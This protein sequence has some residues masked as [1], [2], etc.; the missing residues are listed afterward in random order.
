MD[1]QRQLLDVLDSIEDAFDTDDL[2]IEFSPNVEAPPTVVE[3][4]GALTSADETEVTEHD[5]VVALAPKRPIGEDFAIRR[6][7]HR[8]K[9]IVR[10]GAMP[11]RLTTS[12]YLEELYRTENL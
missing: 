9:P 7:A 10:A 3:G 12:A 5:I 8:D 6:R 4:R 1:K 11:S 2:S